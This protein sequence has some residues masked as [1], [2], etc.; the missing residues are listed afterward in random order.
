M[1]RLG[2]I[3]EGA[4]EKIILEHSDFF[5]YLDGLKIDYIADVI[6]AEG[7]GN[8]LPHNLVRHIQILEDK[9]ATHIFI[10][11]DLDDEEC[12]TNTKARISPLANQTVIVSIKEIE[13]W[14]LADHEV[15]RKYMDDPA[16]SYE[17]P[18]SIN[19]PFEEIK[20]IRKEK[21]GKGLT[22]KK[23]L[24]NS[25]VRKHKFSLL[26]AASHPG[27]SSAKYFMDKIAA[28]AMEE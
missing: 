2:F 4:T 14:F 1:V 13:S 17:Q 3:V 11:T 16:F 5:N 22:D 18:E 28:V 21:T 7:N 20:L 25:L 9:G 27:C 8:L 6:D 12:I 26:S 10:V 23:I 24:A 19:D 15:M